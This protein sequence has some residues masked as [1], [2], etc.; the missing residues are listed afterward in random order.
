MTDYSVEYT[1]TFQS[2]LREH[3]KEWSEAY[4]FSDEKITKFVRS[5]YKSIELTKI[6]P[7]MHEEI[8]RVYGFDKPTYRILIG[9]NYAIFYRIDK[10]QNKILVGNLYNQKQM[11]L[12][13]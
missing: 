9:K 11:Q 6:F 4:F 5:I 12:D 13:F 10:V 8:S 2:S 3:I 1:K 7:E